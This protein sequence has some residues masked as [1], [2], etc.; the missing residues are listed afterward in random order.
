VTISSE[1]ARRVLEA[2]KQKARE[3]RSQVSIAIVDAGGHLVVFERMMAPYG[4]ATGDISIAK[5]HTAV[6]FNQSTD[7][8]A[9]WGSTIPGFAASLATMTHGQ[10]IMTAGGWPLRVNDITIGGIG[11][12]GGNAPGRDDEIARAGLDALQALAPT[13]PTVPPIPPA[14]VAPPP[15][16]P[17]QLAPLPSAPY[18]QPLYAQVSSYHQEDSTNR[19]STVRIAP[20]NEAR[21]STF[22]LSQ[23][24]SENTERISALPKPNADTSLR[25]NSASPPEVDHPG[26]QA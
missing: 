21:P 11:I 18:S 26:D 3:L 4:F 9:Q 14:P 20:T 22:H 6:M 10:F 24:N 19:E 7:E 5:A 25:S 23:D 1:I 17:S 16:Y 12:S 2:S 8:V 13:I 15:A